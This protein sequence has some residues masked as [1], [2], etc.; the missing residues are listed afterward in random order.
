M[1]EI[2]IQPEVFARLEAIGAG[3]HG[4]EFSGL[5]FVRIEDQVFVVYDFVLLHVGSY[6][7]TE[8]PAERVLPPL[9]DRPDAANLKCWVHKHPLGNGLPGP[10][11][12][13]GTDNQTI[14]EA[15]LGGVP[16]L[17]GWSISM[18][19]T[20]KG[21]VGR[22]DNHRSKRT[23]HL[24]VTP[25]M[26]EVLAEVEKLYNERVPIPVI[27]KS[28]HNFYQELFTFA[29]RSK[30]IPSGPAIPLLP[31]GVNGEELAAIEAEAQ[32][33]LL[34]ERM[35][36]IAN[37]DPRAFHENLLTFCKDNG[38]RWLSIFTTKQG[39]TRVMA[40]PPN[41]EQD[42][43]MPLLDYLDELDLVQTYR[44]LAHAD[45]VEIFPIP[46]LLL[47]RWRL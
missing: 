4:M 33:I 3:A 1:P 18:V 42:V 34:A 20:P 43:V 46:G 10:Q 44:P 21:W 6:S 25:S 36:T 17:V 38:Y 11:N 13:S 16:E 24:N 22:M 8:I 37:L 32:D 31:G 2:H 7:Y 45:E 15:P 47:G 26:V 19:R 29:G 39:Q 23:V 41:P 28:S 12:W 35:E 14:A 40:G 5:G 9:L 27:Q 30:N